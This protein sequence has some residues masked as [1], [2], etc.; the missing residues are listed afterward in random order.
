[1]KKKVE[2]K[3]QIFSRYNCSNNSLN[4]SPEEKINNLY[5]NDIKLI[6]TKKETE[7]DEKE[8]KEEKAEKKEKEKKLEIKEKKERQ[9]IKEKKVYDDYELN[10]ME[11]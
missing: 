8:E 10:E 2:D 11:Y 4:C 5:S 1:M 3:I 6:K 7:K 9:E